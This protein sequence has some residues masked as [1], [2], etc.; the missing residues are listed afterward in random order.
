V[1]SSAFDHQAV[2][3]RGLLVSLLTSSPFSTFLVPGLIL[4]LVVGGTQTVA[5]VRLLQHRPSALLCSAVAG[6][7]MVV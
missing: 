4:A 1:P 7:G 3:R 5:M 2:G 6:F